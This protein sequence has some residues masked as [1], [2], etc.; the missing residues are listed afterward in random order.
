M[1]A[2]VILA[3]LLVTRAIWRGGTDPLSEE[4]KKEGERY[5]IKVFHSPAEEFRLTDETLQRAAVR[6]LS[7]WDEP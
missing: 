1:L 5:W 4:L 6:E 7:D 2:M 3:N